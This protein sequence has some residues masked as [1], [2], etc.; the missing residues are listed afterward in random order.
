M[1]KSISLLIDIL[2]LKDQVGSLPICKIGPS[3]VLKNL[4]K[5]I[6]K[7]NLEVEKNKQIK[8][9][10]AL[11]SFAHFV[12]TRKMSQTNRLATLAIGET[13]WNQIRNS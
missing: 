12:S 8:L 11:S 13:E 5:S 1:I 3:L 4:K 7:I 2:C 9:A 6:N 10:F